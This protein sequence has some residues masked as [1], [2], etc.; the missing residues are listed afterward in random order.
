MED[1]LLLE[2]NN[3]MTTLHTREEI[4]KEYWTKVK[5]LG[6]HLG[7]LQKP[8]MEKL[9]SH[10]DSIRQQDLQA[11]KE[12]AEEKKQGDGLPKDDTKEIRLAIAYTVGYNQALSELTTFL[13]QGE[14]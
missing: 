4:E 2:K 10:I 6:L 14:E 1:K 13:S 3:S 9:L 7:Y 11:I 5:E 12:W 8:Q